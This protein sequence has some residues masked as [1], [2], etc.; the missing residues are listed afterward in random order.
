MAGVIP[1]GK[2]VTD[3]DINTIKATT[4]LKDLKQAVQSA[5]SA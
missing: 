5:T 1:N 2:I 3:I 4:S